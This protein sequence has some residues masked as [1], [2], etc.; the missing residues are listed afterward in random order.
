MIEADG[1]VVLALLGSNTLIYDYLSDSTVMKGVYTS[2]GQ[3][4]DY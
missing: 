4:E 3:R 2:A 1:D